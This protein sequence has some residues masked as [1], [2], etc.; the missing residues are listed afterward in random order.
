MKDIQVITGCMFAGKTT[1]LIR[2]LKLIN[3]N[4][5]LVKP[6]VDTRDVGSQICTHDGLFER[7]IQVDSL[8]EIS[9]K[10]KNIEVLGIDEAQFF[11]K[12]IVQDIKDISSQGIIIIIAGLA[13]DYLNKSFGCMD[14]IIE[15]STST[16]WLTAKCNQCNKP[17]EYSHRKAMN[18]TNQVLIGNANEYEALCEIC[19]NKTQ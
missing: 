3:K 14:D 11:K 1:E 6:K 4:Y 15:I 7:G 18:L 2:R 16:T 5:L 8:S 9:N 10:L 17:A 13:K 12:S 19:F